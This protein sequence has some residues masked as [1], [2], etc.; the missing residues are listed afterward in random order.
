MF[1]MNFVSFV[2]PVSP[3]SHAVSGESNW[4]FFGTEL[5]S[6]IR[7]RSTTEVE[8]EEQRHTSGIWQAGLRF[9]VECIRRK[10][11][12]IRPKDTGTPRGQCPDRGKEALEFKTKKKKTQMEYSKT[13]S[14][15]PCVCERERERERKRK[16][17]NVMGRGEEKSTKKIK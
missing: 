5:N 12:F 11:T 15:R 9:K 16:I 6:N 17:E 1:Y 4:F 8:H 7:P 10:K 3:K 13:A 14:E 2:F